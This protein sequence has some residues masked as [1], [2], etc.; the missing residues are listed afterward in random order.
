MDTTSLT[1]AF[2]AYNNYEI[3][4]KNLALEIEKT[5]SAFFHAFRIENKLTVLQYAK[6][7]HF[8]ANDLI[9]QSLFPQ[10]KR[11]EKKIQ[12]VSE[13]DT[14][15]TNNEHRH[16]NINTYD[17]IFVVAGNI[18]ASK[19]SESDSKRQILDLIGANEDVGR[20]MVNVEMKYGE[21]QDVNLFAGNS[22][23]SIISVP[24]Q[25][26]KM[27]AENI[28]HV[29]NTN[30]LGPVEL[31]KRM[32]LLRKNPL[33][34]TWDNRKLAKVSNALKEIKLG[35]FQTYQHENSSCK[36]IFIVYRGEVQLRKEGN[37]KPSRDNNLEKKYISQQQN[38]NVRR[39]T[40]L[41]ILGPSNIGSVV[42]MVQ[43]YETK[44]A[45]YRSTIL[46]GVSG[47]TILTMSSYMANIL[48]FSSERA[49][50][51]LASLRRRR[52]LWDA[53][54][55][56]QQ[57]RHADISVTLNNS[58]MMINFGYVLTES[59]VAHLENG[60]AVRMNVNN[61]KDRFSKTKNIQDT[62][63]YFTLQNARERRRAGEALLRAGEYSVAISTFTIANDMFQESIELL[64]KN[65]CSM[66]IKEDIA[67]TLS[68]GF[69]TLGKLCLSLAA[70]AAFVVRK[71]LTNAAIQYCKL[72]FSRR[73]YN[74]ATTLFIKAHEEWKLFLRYY[75]TGD[76]FKQ[77]A[78]LNHH[79]KIIKPMA[80]DLINKMA[81]LT[82]LVTRVDSDLGES[83]VTKNCKSRRTSNPETI[84]PFGLDDG[85]ESKQAHHNNIPSP[86]HGRK[87][88]IGPVNSPRFQHTKLLMV[89]R[90]CSDSSDRST[91][92]KNNINNLALKHDSKVVI[93]SHPD[94]VH[95]GH[96]H[97]INPSY[98]NPYPSRRDQAS[99]ESKTSI[100]NN[101]YINISK[102]NKSIN[103]ILRSKSRSKQLYKNQIY[104]DHVGYTKFPLTTSSNRSE[105]KTLIDGNDSKLS[106]SPPDQP[107]IRQPTFGID[108]LLIEPNE[109]AARLFGYLLTT[110]AR[111][112]GIGCNFTH[113]RG[114]KAGLR[115]SGNTNESYS[116]SATPSTI[117]LTSNAMYTLEKSSNAFTA[118]I[119]AVEVHDISWRSVVEKVRM[120]NS[121]TLIY[122]IANC[123][124]EKEEEVS[125]VKTTCKYGGNG[126]Y[127]K[128]YVR[129]TASSILMN[130][131]KFHQKCK[132]KENNFIFNVIKDGTRS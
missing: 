83:N 32:Q 24:Y 132:R 10:T 109:K 65:A 81:Q 124:N 60:D 74:K 117:G 78:D 1:Q 112:Y 15:A 52:L 127:K 95:N 37:I 94:A 23:C 75:G 110:Q 2:E 47:A 105:K 27:F 25:K 71:T 61:A 19:K 31:S 70:L 29:E 111:R 108:I 33:T 91:S 104:R 46:A 87:H 4:D 14:S 80:K 121:R 64:S 101:E 7:I 76:E 22:G 130:I 28:Q 55:L 92:K 119:V 97:L 123:S 59:V 8:E 6:M 34:S 13:D 44:G 67:Y 122:T 93:H 99:I 30:R 131:E 128:P 129:G 9:S 16:G 103:E 18:K 100:R 63:Y 118:I 54:R 98:R 40:I 50:N 116:Y 11:G 72:N 62:K 115:L 82:R 58:R 5:H 38:D 120:H 106:A 57:N 96:H 79:Y 66:N 88:S 41:A 45:M 49:Y 12:D 77:Y 85:E 73:S 89:Q 51:I 42:E 113:V 86:P 102:R 84:G 20:L 36:E 43:L 35:A 21:L 48:L 69:K 39:A 53:M 114:G 107:C 26:Y 68:T 126:F 3:T 125:F 56:D 17:Y 90:Q